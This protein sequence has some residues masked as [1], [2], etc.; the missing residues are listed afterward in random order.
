MSHRLSVPGR[1]SSAH[2]CC[3]LILALLLPSLVG[4]G[5]QEGSQPNSPA[6]VSPSASTNAPAAPPQSYEVRGVIKETDLAKRTAR[7]THEEIP[8]YMRKMTMEFSVRDQSDL[9]SLQPGDSVTFTMKVTEEDGWIENLKRSTNVS[10]TAT[11][12][13]SPAPASRMKVAPY[14]PLFPGDTLP[15]YAFTNEFNQ[16]VLLSQ[17]EGQALA[18]TFIF[19]TC[20]FPT[21]CPRMSANFREAYQLLKALPTGET[22]WHLFSITIDPA[23]DTPEVLKR[24]AGTQNYDAKHWS[25]LTGAEDQ[26]ELLARHFGLNFYREGGVLNH[27]LRTVV[28]NPKGK[29]HKTLIGNE[30]KAQEL[31]DE[32]VSAWGG[33]PTPKEP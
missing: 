30:W 9:K 8:G 21:M 7:I 4:C 5:P 23:T 12:K 13:E 32:L 17:Y 24:Y 16:P 25:F 3:L 2:R 14:E 18:F 20:P 11:V 1:E 29:V 26:I 28:I 31:V 33:K 15:D 22:N 19:T 27:N 10:S 6:A